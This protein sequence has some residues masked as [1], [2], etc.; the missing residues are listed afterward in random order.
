[1]FQSLNL[2]L[3]NVA[4]KNFEKKLLLANSK[5]FSVTP[6]TQS[7]QAT[8]SAT[9]VHLSST[10]TPVFILQTTSLKSFLGMTTKSATLTKFSISSPAW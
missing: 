1:M 4:E 6:K 5:V 8:S 2:G 3:A 10:P 7:F 9:P